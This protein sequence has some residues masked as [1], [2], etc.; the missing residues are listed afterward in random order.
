M[1]VLLTDV[2]VTTLIYRL[3]KYRGPGRSVGIATGY[4]LRRSGDRNPVGR[5]FPQ[6]SRLALG[7]TQPPVK[8]IRGLSRG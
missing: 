8:W 5:D 7:H 3:V 2:N 1:F 6:V 4:W